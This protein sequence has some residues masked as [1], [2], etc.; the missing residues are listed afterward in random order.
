MKYCDIAVI[1][2]GP[3]G[4]KAAIQAAKA[5]RSVILI[6]RAAAV[7]GGCV[8]YGT[9]PSKTLREAALQLAGV[10]RVISGA[11]LELGTDF[12]VEN[13]MTRLGS[14]VSQHE[15]YMADQLKRNNI[16]LVIG[17]ATFQDRGVIEVS[18]GGGARELIEFDGAVI[19]TG[20]RPRRPAFAEIDHDVIFDSDSILAIER[21][22]RSLV[23]LGAGVIAA[24]YASIF[25]CL[26]VDVTMVDNR[27]RPIPFIDPELTE[28]FISAFLSAGGTYLPKQQISA[29]RRT[30]GAAVV[31]LDGE[32]PRHLESEA[33]LVALG[34]L[35]NRDGLNLNA[36]EIEVSERGTII[37]DDNGWT[38][39][40]KIYAIGDVIGP[41]SLAS[42][43]MDQGRRA[44]RSLIGLPASHSPNLIPAGV[45]TIPAISCVG[46]SEAVAREKYGDAIVGRAPY[47]EIA[48]G[49]ISGDRDGLIKLIFEP[50]QQRLVGVHIIGTSAAEL[51]HVGQ[52]ALVAGWTIDD[53][54]DNVF[55]FPTFAE[56]Y[57]IAALS[58]GKAAKVAA[59]RDDG[60]LRMKRASAALG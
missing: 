10:R 4:Q 16:E 44:A 2:S 56:G 48:R 20:S 55:N 7:G 17:T 18:S 37:V 19:A 28:R 52:V 53:L 8:H 12:E 38:G 24:E 39:V 34:R 29:V 49:C 33:A 50:A 42:T 25:A 11:N 22:P 6:E 15:T 41:P 59:E 40:D 21:L 23:V 46:L 3:G 54:I 58:A 1:G 60:V 27:D 57:R 32:R 35:A 5:G 51:V 31:E 45:Y 30:A 13:L 36:L 43:S 9:I 26:G 14:V 47:A